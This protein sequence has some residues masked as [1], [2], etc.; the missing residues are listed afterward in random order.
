MSYQRAYRLAEQLRRRARFRAAEQEQPNLFDTMVLLYEIGQRNG[1]PVNKITAA[2]AS[3]G[4][5]TTKAAYNMGSRVYSAFTSQS[6][7]KYTDAF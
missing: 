7:T 1:I 5:V 3:A 4:Y 6:D 2:I